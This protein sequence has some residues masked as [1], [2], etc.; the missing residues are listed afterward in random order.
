MIRKKGDVM[1]NYTI[2]LFVLLISFIALWWLSAYL[3]LDILWFIIINLISVYIILKY[4]KFDKVNTVVG[5]IFGGL[6]IPSS[7]IMGISVV[8]PYIA[9]MM[10]FKDCTNKIFLYK[11]NKKNNFLN[12]ILLI[13]V[14]GGILAIINVI[15][16]MGSMTIN[17]SFKF[18]WIFDALCAGIFEE[19]FFRL[20]LFALCIHLGNN[21]PLTTLQNII[22]YLIMI[23]PHVLIHFNLQTI[24]I[25][26]V[27]TLSILFGIPFAIMQRKFNLISAIGSHAFVDIVRFCIFSI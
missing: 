1:K 20:F 25:D 4:R 18:K 21:K 8:L 16:A 12:S 27:I 26:S 5:I 6:C 24:H 7:F 10:V 15:L 23:I 9:S 17:V 14:I 11:N 22:C 2:K 13:F 3:S 19:I